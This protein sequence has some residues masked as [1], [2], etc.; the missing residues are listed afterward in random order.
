REMT[1]DLFAVKQAR[2]VCKASGYFVVLSLQAD[3]DIPAMMPQGHP[4][5]IDVGLEYFLS[6]SDGEQVKRPRFFNELHRKLKLL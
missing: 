2:I 3:V 4:I 5:G 1:P 6:T